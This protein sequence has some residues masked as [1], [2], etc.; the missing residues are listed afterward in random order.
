MEDLHSSGHHTQ[1]PA[2]KHSLTKDP[3]SD[4]KIVDISAEELP[5]KRPGMPTQQ[6]I[7]DNIQMEGSSGGEHK[8]SQTIKVVTYDHILK[9]RP[10]SKHGLQTKGWKS[11]QDRIDN[12]SLKSEEHHTISRDHMVFGSVSHRDYEADKINQSH[13]PQQMRMYLE[14]SASQ[15]AQLNNI[16]PVKIQNLNVTQ[17]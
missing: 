12:L 17:K 11:Q 16:P 3:Q 7:S 1:P 9:K 15:L 5:E 4:L 6:Q 14:K 8:H 10:Q 13:Q 2:L